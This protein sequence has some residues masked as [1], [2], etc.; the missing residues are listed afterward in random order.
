MC[1]NT[2]REDGKEYSPCG[3]EIIRG[4]RFFGGDPD[5]LECTA[6]VYP[7]ELKPNLREEKDV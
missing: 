2:K 5:E 7:V 4:M 6:L 1:G 3:C